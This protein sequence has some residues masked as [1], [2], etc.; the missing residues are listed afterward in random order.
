MPEMSQAMSILT[1]Q[2]TVDWYTPPEWI[3][4]ARQVLG[5]I[6]LDPASD[7][8]PQQW[9]KAEKYY[10]KEQDGLSKSWFG[11]VWLNPPFADTQRFVDYLIE[12]F[13]TGRTREAILL[14][15]SNLGYRWFED[16]WIKYPVCMVRDRIR[17]IKADGT[18]GG[19]AKRAQCFVLLH[20]QYDTLFKFTEVFQ[21]FGRVLMPTPPMRLLSDRELSQ[22]STAK[23]IIA[24][25]LAMV[26]SLY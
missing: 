7:E 18:S 22:V 15:N 13:E 17:F 5:T 9:I 12:E 8:L 19:Q 4:R 16:L 11:N 26:R 25:R 24:T 2:A 10:T 1:S 23:E 14:V 3:E 20:R 6:H 21:E